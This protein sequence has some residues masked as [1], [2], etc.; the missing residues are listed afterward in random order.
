MEINGPIVEIVLDHAP[1]NALNYQTYEELRDAF[2]A[3]DSAT[4][5]IFRGDGR[6]F[7]AG[8]DIRDFG[9]LT[10]ETRRARHRLIGAMH[11]NLAAI[12]VP[13][14]CAIHGF[15]IGAGMVT[16]AFADVRLAAETAFFSMPEADR[17]QTGL[18]G[19]DLRRAGLSVGL[20]R[21]MLFTGERYSAQQMQTAGFVQRV[22]A[23]GDLIDAARSMAATIASK[24]RPTL[25]AMKKASID[26]MKYANV[27][28]A[29]SA[30]HEIAAELM[31][32][33][34]AKEGSQAY[35]EKRAPS[36]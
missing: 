30:Q 28:D 17:G 11:G 23:D 8:A 31:V 7:C 34:G 20:V 29:L 21:E 4:V 10:P 5:V 22:V 2:A 1:V 9:A 14:I 33:A 18:G 27:D 35:L 6:G 25:I 13:V 26:E 12:P 15:A 16:A 24:H 36:Y 32:A 3:C 19:K